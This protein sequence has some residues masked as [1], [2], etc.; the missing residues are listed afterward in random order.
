MAKS[1][2]TETVS[3]DTA[4]GVAVTRPEL[5]AS[6]A[7]RVSRSARVLL[8]DDNVDL[9][10]CLARL[11]EIHGHDVRIA[12]DG[13]SGIDQARAWNP[14]FVLLDIG[15]PGMDGFQVASLLRQNEAT[16]DTVIIAISGYGHEEDRARSKQAGFDHHLVKPINSDELAMIMANPR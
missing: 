8:I 15:L 16:Q 5:S 7:Q 13:P 4:R 6:P 1:D 14:E 9:A 10:R 3:E 2:G 11:L 12:H